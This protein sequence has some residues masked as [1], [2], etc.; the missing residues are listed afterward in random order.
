MKVLLVQDMLIFGTSMIRSPLTITGHNK[1]N[2]NFELPSSKDSI[3]ALMDKVPDPIHP[4]RGEEK[5]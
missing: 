1:K 2:L 3:Q 5:K 4:Y